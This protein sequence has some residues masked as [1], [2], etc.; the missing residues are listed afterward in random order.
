MSVKVYR[1]G[2]S[3]VI[4]KD[5]TGDDDFFISSK[6]SFVIPVVNFSSL[7]KYMVFNDVIS[8][9]VLQ[10]IVDEFYNKEN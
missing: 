8:P 7:V 9:K 3:I 6:N 4:R 5:D 2:T 10:G 1:I